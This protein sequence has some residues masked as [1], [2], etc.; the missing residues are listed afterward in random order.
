[1]SDSE[2]NYTPPESLAGFFA[3]DA[4]LR[5][6]RGPIG[7]TKSTAMVM[8]LFRRMCEQEPGSDGKRRT[9]FAIVRN[10]LPQ[11]KE[12]CL[13]TV[14]KTLGPL[15]QYKVSESKMIFDFNDVYSEWLMLPLDSPENVQ[16]LLSLELTGAWVSEFREVSPEIVRNVYSRCSRYPAAL[17]GGTNPTWYGLIAETN[18]FSEDSPWFD[19]LELNKPDSWYYLVQPGAYDPKADWLQYLTKTYYADLLEANG[20]HWARQ[21]IHN[22]ITP[23]LSSQAV[24]A[25]SFDQ[26]YHVVDELNFIH[27]L[28]LVLGM[29][30]GRNPAC[31]A[32]Q[33]D[34]RGRVNILASLHAEN[35]GMEQFL[36]DHVQPMLMA[37]FERAYA[38]AIVDPAGRSRSQIGEESVIECIKR[39]GI[40]A[41]PASTNQI[42][43]RLRAVEG[44]LNR[45]DGMAID[46]RYNHQLIV[47]LRYGY[48]FARAK[49][50]ALKEL[51]DKSHPDSDLAD[52]LQYLCLG[53]ES[54]MIGRHVQRAKGGGSQ[55][56]EPTAAGWT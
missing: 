5:F 56:R 3:S 52:A 32:G 29:D 53:I 15:M 11:I 23:S 16:R 19:E 27:S 41:Y 35:M 17:G 13:V 33:L 51:P 31:V 24:F 47:A 30:T 49:D 21:Y 48:R 1:M 40:P 42:S 45:R 12:T 2:F 50:L 20:E 55:P 46:A 43:P 22:E 25:K 18:S 7:S 39:C 44:Y 6:V 14:R 54:R 34:P 38:Y 28:P 8:E 36:Q 26:D 37:S 4:R 10:T 9:R